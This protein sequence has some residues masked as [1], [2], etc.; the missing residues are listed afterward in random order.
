[1]VNGY[2]LDQI[3]GRVVEDRAD[4]AR[5]LSASQGNPIVPTKYLT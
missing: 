4:P 3:T 1:M 5:P 2:E